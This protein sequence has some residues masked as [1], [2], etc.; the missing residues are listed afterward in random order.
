MIVKLLEVSQIGQSFSGVLDIPKNSWPQS[1]QFLPCQNLTNDSDVGFVNLFKVI[2]TDE[3]LNVGPLPTRWQ[4][5]DRIACLPPHGKGFTLP[6]SARRVGL[7][8]LTTSPIYLLTL[9]ATAF[10]QGAAVSLF[11]E[12]IPPMD[13]LNHVPPRVEVNQIS[14]LSENPDWLDYLAVDINYLELKTLSKLFN[15][16]EL[17]FEGQVL[18][19][20]P[21]PCRGL[22]DCGVCAVKTR[23]GWR[24]ACADGPVFPLKEVLHVA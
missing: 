24:M 10:A 22:G 20:T 13:L 3:V 9:A 19:R 11:C 12:S 15:Q 14:A 2:G 17:L 4:P 18:I 7:L 8:T 21:M 16:T 6:L 1:G 23:S 5:G